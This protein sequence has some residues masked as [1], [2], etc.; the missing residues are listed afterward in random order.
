MAV[1]PAKRALRVANVSYS[2]GMKPGGTVS[3]THHAKAPNTVAAFAAEQTCPKHTRS[4]KNTASAMK[5]ANQ[6]S[7]VNVSTP[8]IANLWCAGELEKRHGTMM[9]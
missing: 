1:V 4:L 5:P 3:A 8:R 2:C 7:M 6:K 9:R